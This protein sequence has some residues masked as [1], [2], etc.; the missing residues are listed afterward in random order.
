MWL[1]DIAIK[2]PVFTVMVFIALIVMGIRS[3]TMMPVDKLPDMDVPIVTITTVYPGAGPEEIETLVT[4]RIEDQVS[5]VDKVDTVQ[6][7]SREGI[8]TI[9]MEFLMEADIDV[10]TADVRAKIA[11]AKKD[12]PDDAEEPIVSKLDLGA[13]PVITMGITSDTM[14]IRE[15]KTLVKNVIADRFAKQSGVGNVEVSGGDTREI[16]ILADQDRLVA[17]S[18]TIYELKNLLQAANLNIP[19]G[20]MKPGNLENAIKMQGEFQSIE[21]I[22]DLRISKM[23]EDG[24]QSIKLS[25]IADVIDGNADR[26]SVTRL[27]GIDSVGLTIRKQGSANSLKTVG[28]VKKELEAVKKDYPQLSIKISDDQSINIKNSI[29]SVFHEL[30]LGGILAVIVIF[31]F[32]HNFRFVFIVILALPSPMIATFMILFA[33]GQTLNMMSLMGLTL[34][35]GILIDDTIV[36][37]ENIHRHLKM[38]KDP[39]TAAFDGRTEIGLAAIAITMTDCVVYLPVAFMGGVVGRAFLSFGITVASATLFSL[40]TSYTLTPMLASQWLREES[41][42]EKKKSLS[43]R[44]FRLFDRFYDGLDSIYRAVLEKALKVRWLVVLIGMGSL[45]VALFFIAPRIQVEFTPQDDQGKIRILIELPTDVNV[46]E[47]DR[48]TK[49]IEEVI[50][51]KEDFPEVL[52]VFTN[53]GAEAG[54]LISSGAQGPE[55]ASIDIDVGQRGE[56]KRSV[57]EIGRIMTEKLSRIPYDITV[58]YPKSLGSGAKPVQI[59]VTGNRFQMEDLLKVSEEVKEITENTSGPVDVGISWKEGRP[60]TQVIV[61]RAKLSSTNFTVGYIGTVL[62]TSVAGNTD[63]K[64]REFGEEYDIRVRLQEKY[65]TENWQTGEIYIGDIN[66]KPV[67]IK[68]VADLVT[69]PA[70]N[71]IDH[72]NKQI[73]VIISAELEQ[74]AALGNIQK[75]IEKTIAEKITLPAGISVKFGG[76]AKRMNES[77]GY[78]L[79]AIVLAIILVYLVMASIFESYLNPFIIMFALPQAMVGGFLALYLTASTL[80]IFSMIGF[81]MLIGLVGK[82]AILLIDY[83]NTLRSRGMARDEALKQAGPARLRP[84][85]MTTVALIFALIPVA[86]G[87]GAG[88]ELRQPMSIAVIGGLILSTL[89]TLLV[90]PVLYAQFD[91]LMNFL[92][93]IRKGSSA[94]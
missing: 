21:E 62:R 13:L 90:I 68:N 10:A 30:L 43:D 51:N 59:E 39:K 77:F 89:L 78:M 17:Y 8:S 42:E 5:S 58:T 91:D 31:I 19:G 2:R 66:G 82:N 34:C 61:D 73:A 79:E 55:Y 63:I 20:N 86:L 37:L 56:R 74:G 14:N 6:S 11:I 29:E 45:F 64:Y 9:I 22:K 35:I 24:P 40:F 76:D 81:I 32:L 53:V 54:S 18:M 47:T 48:I 87:M 72:R 52:S 93:R 85:L 41:K 67:Y 33:T 65:R 57:F 94:A 49:K 12:L 50:N 46:K 1:T 28:A 88:A 26:E 71:N 83:T 36:V 69:K 27:D 7:V 38:G 80:S 4:K 16:L 84:I 15:V 23:T 92:R 3:L 75:K 44:F 70:P 60:E 25:D